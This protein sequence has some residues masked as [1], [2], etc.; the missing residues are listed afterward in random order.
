MEI[1]LEL[2]FGEL[3]A[4]KEMGKEAEV[5]KVKDFKEISTRGVM[6]TPAVIILQTQYLKSH[7]DTSGSPVD[8]FKESSNKN[9]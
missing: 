2:L 1:F 6:M 4:L 3:N 7:L 5:V 8:K 9:K